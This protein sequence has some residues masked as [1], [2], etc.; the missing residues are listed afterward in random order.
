MGMPHSGF[1]I[2][3]TESTERINHP[4]DAAIVS[5]EVAVGQERNLT[6]TGHGYELVER[7]ILSMSKCLSNP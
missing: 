5:E 4:G 2:Y 1:S 7:E 6:S 3:Q